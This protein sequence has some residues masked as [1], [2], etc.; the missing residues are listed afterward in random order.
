MYDTGEVIKPLALTEEV[1]NYIERE[2]AK[3]EK[4]KKRTK[5]IM[6]YTV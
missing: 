1:Q 3:K 6:D 2:S 5:K 4:K